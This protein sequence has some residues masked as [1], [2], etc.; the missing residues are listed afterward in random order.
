L[1]QFKLR[2]RALAPIAH[3]ADDLEWLALGRHHGLPT[4]FLDWTTSV[5]T[6]AFFACQTGGVVGQSQKR[7]AIYAV[8]RPPLVEKAREAYGADEPVAYHPPHISPRITAQNGLLTFHQNPTEPWQPAELCKYW[9]TSKAAIQIR[10]A[11]VQAGINESSLMPGL[12]GIA[13]HLGWLY[14][15][16]FLSQ[17]SMRE[18][19]GGA[20]AYTGY[21]ARGGRHYEVRLTSTVAT[22]AA[23][24]A[25]HKTQ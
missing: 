10:V 7:P 20:F 4:P 9:I 23:L 17:I 18:D 8:T 5:F 12:D 13:A 21:N 25:E 1:K 15:R 16:E 6:A 24:V 19:G 14:K 22:A 3:D 11:L 2:A